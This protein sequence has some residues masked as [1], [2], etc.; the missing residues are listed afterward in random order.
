MTGRDHS[1]KTKLAKAKEQL[2]VPTVAERKQQMI[3]RE[4]KAGMDICL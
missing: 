4:R 3:R 2:K 1:I